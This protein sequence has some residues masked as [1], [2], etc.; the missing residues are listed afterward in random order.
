MI[1]NRAFAVNIFLPQV[2]EHENAD[3]MNGFRD[4][5][6]IPSRGRARKAGFYALFSKIFSFWLQ[7]GV[8]YQ[9]LKERGFKLAQIF[10]CGIKI[11]AAFGSGISAVA[12]KLMPF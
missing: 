6:K 9:L 5:R 11:D 4:F 2:V 3:F 8:S 12:S 1:K 7:I 10:V